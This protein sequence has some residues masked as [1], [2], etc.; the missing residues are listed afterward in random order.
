MSFIE[1]YEIFFRGF[2]FLLDPGFW[3]FCFA[4]IIFLG[5]IIG[6]IGLVYF[7]YSLFK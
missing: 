4:L 3:G 7:I 1:G 5:I 6:L 2:S